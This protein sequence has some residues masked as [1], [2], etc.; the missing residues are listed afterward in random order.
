MKNLLI[1]YGETLTN[2]VSVK[3]GSGEK[4]HPYTLEE[5]RERLRENL[6]EI[7]NLIEAKPSN[8]C[9]NDEVVIKFIQHPSY[10][11]KTYYP[12]K[13]FKKFGMRDVGTK[14]IKVKPEKWGVKKHP[15]IGL[16][17][18]IYVSGTKLEF[19]NMLDVLNNGKIDEGILKLIRTIE[20]ISL[21]NADE[22]IKYLEESPKVNRLE[23]V[24]HASAEEDSI[25]NFFNEYVSEMGGNVEVNKKKI[26]GGLTF[27]PVTVERG[28]EEKLA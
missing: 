5:G 20:N 15:E 11:A 23:V 2:V 6:S 3:N 21:F 19:Q 7:I 16:S 18:C 9:A 24:I 12:R 8:S 10:L 14:S 17:S 4:S 25:I 13:L 26:V 22:K 28:K 27:I 1:G